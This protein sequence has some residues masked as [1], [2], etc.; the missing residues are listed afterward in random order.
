M[1]TLK[2]PDTAA[3]ALIRR[4]EAAMAAH[5]ESALCRLAEEAGGVDG[6]S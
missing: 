4:T 5:P 6:R 1:P 2:H 3:T